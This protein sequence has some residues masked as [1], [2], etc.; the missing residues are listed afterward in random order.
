MFQFGGAWSFVG[1]LSPRKPPMATGLY[2]RYKEIVFMLTKTKLSLS[3][4]L[5]FVA[6]RTNVNDVAIAGLEH[7]CSIIST[8]TVGYDGHPFDT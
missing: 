2:E 4:L 1:G 7:L 8:L 6:Y 5:F 3:P